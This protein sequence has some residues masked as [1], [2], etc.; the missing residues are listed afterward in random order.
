MHFTR[1]S[2]SWLN[3]V[4]RFFR[5]I[6]ERRIRRSA[7]A[8]LANLKSAIIDHFAVHNANPKPF[9]WTAKVSD[10]LANVIRARAALNK[11]TSN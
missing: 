1:D 7:F 9:I 10:I 5:D 4:E 8:S 3:M 2:A 6:T 11:R